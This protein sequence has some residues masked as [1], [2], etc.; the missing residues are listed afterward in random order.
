MKK[1][2]LLLSAFMLITFC[3]SAQK[4]KEVKVKTAREFLY[5]LLN[6]A[7]T[8]VI[9]SKKPLNLTAELNAMKEEGQ[10]SNISALDDVTISDI[11]YEENE[12]LGLVIQGYHGLTIKGKNPKKSQIVIDDRFPDVIQFRNC[13]NIT[14][15]NLTLG[16]TVQGDMGWCHGDVLQTIQCDKIRVRNCVLFGCGVVGIDA[17]HTT[18]M[19]VEKTEIHHCSWD[20]I[21]LH[22]SDYL[23]KDC[24][25]HHCHGFILNQA[26]NVAFENCTLTNLNNELFGQYN[27]IQPITMTNCKVVHHDGMGNSA[28]KVKFVDCDLK[29]DNEGETDGY[30][31]MNGEE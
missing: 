29:V 5:A 11:F 26:T 13:G 17:D 24:T 27:V 7:S 9:A 19:V 3:A 20:A 1:V 16:H 8:I 6:D 4:A 2:L 12:G 15:E 22:G 25:F 14:L 28:D 23:F 10:I 21:Q 31:P 30:S 18:D